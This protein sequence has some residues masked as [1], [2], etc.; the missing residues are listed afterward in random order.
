MPQ[1]QQDAFTNS[2]EI[3][4]YHQMEIQEIFAGIRLA[5]SL[6]VQIYS[7]F[8]T[9][10]LTVLGFALGIN[11]AGLI[12][13]AASMLGVLILAN[14]RVRKYREFLLVRGLELEKMYAPDVEH[15]YFHL[16]D[17]RQSS[18]SRI[19]N[20]SLPVFI[21]SIEI[22]MAILSWLLLGWRWF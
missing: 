10:N 19:K 8:G 13:I 14:R 4:N 3:N 20:Y 6:T 16:F 22:A 21:F 15:A 11:S 5:N 1:T 7:F 9:A 12:L 18:K 2:T 17:S